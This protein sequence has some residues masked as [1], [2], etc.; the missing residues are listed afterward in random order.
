M[1]EGSIL[2][3]LLTVDTIERRRLADQL[4]Q[5]V[6]QL[7]GED[8][9]ADSQSDLDRLQRACSWLAKAYRVGDV[10]D[11]EA[12]FI[13]SWIA[14]NSMCG[15][16]QQCL[17]CLEK[18]T[19]L[20]LSNQIGRRKSDLT[21]L[22]WFLWRVSDLDAER[23]I[24]QVL[25]KN[26]QGVDQILH[27]QFL[28]KAYWDME[29]DEK[30]RSLRKSDYEGAARALAGGDSY[31]CLYPLFVYRL[32]ILR[33]LIFHGS[34]TDRHSKRRERDE[35]K[36][37]TATIVLEKSGGAFLAVM[38]EAGASAK[39]PRVVGP[40]FESPQRGRSESCKFSRH[41]GSGLKREKGAR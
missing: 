34:S 35:A 30:V 4:E 26:R 33:N 24:V 21:D 11:L 12:R 37:E 14:L 10:T 41:C 1:P 36:F 32:R 2:I 18:E 3:D 27:D 17:K 7:R 39:W 15:V 20:L 8:R 40:R 28:Q 19:P 29:H 31:K 16:G 6:I 9:N 25:R 5:R 22:D 38:D 23:R 13:F